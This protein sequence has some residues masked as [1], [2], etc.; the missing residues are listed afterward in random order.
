[1]SHVT[2][3]VFF[4]RCKLTGTTAPRATPDSVNIE[5]LVT[6]GLRR[7]NVLIE[8]PVDLKTSAELEKRMKDINVSVLAFVQNFPLTKLLLI[9][10]AQTIINNF[11]YFYNCT[12]YLKSSMI[13]ALNKTG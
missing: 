13:C 5:E 3:N 12:H 7:I 4:N 6:K 9:A 10:R 11:N 1:M 8:K 2:Y